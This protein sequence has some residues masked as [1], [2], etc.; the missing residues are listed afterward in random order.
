MLWPAGVTVIETRLALKTVR[1]VVPETSLKNAVTTVCPDPTAVA[2]PF[3]LA[4]LLTVATVLTEELQ[5]TELV[6][7]W[8]E[9]SENVPMA[10]NWKVVFRAIWGLDGVIE[11]DLRVAVVTVRLVL[12]GFAPKTAWM[13]VEPAERGVARPL[14]PTALL[15]DATDP[16][17]DPHVTKLVRSYVEPSE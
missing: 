5:V 10:V 9:W 12:V 3:I 13:V 15:M 4:P 11:M 16:I 1:V 2:N 6:R 17:D 8:V 14:E 7:S